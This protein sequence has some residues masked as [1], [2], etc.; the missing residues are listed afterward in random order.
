MPFFF[1]LFLSP[2]PPFLSSPLTPAFLP[3]ECPPFSSE[4]QALHRERCRLCSARWAPAAAPRSPAAGT[5]SPGRCSQGQQPPPRSSSLQSAAGRYPPSTLY[6]HTHTYTR[7]ICRGGRMMLHFNIPRTPWCPSLAPPTPGRSRGATL[8][9]PAPCRL[10]KER[11]AVS[12]DFGKRFL[13]AAASS[14]LRFLSPR[15]H[16]C[17]IPPHPALPQ[18]RYGF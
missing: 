1:S 5:A 18:P 3:S 12:G 9:S 17:C 16:G 10:P 7:G 15:S 6:T 14:D 8:H 11:R 13:T 2:P 4:A